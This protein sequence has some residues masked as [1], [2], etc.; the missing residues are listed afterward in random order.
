MKKILFLFTL[1]CFNN[2]T[3]QIHEV[4]VFIG[5]TSFIGD[6]GKMSYVGLEKP[7][8]GAIYKW[9]QSTRHAWRA[10][11]THAQITGHDNQSNMPSRKARGYSFNNTI[12]E[13][14]L[15][16]EFNFLEYNL[17]DL[18]N[19]FTPYVS[20]GLSGF[21]HNELAIYYGQVYRLQKNKFNMAIP[22]TVGVKAKF[23]SN[24]TVGAEVGFRYTFTDNLDGSHPSNNQLEHLRFGNLNSNDWYVFSGITLTYTFGE[25]P[26]FCLL[27]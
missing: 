27:K 16:L 7:A 12:N 9:N 13:L 19:Q 26:C 22:M 11:F 8:I 23:M 15:G 4:G 5:G 3:A 20:L 21:T 1:L 2:L 24:F 10:S 17:H 18:T 25:N 14:A 6:V